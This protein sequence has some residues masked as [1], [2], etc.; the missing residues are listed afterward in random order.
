[1]KDMRYFADGQ[2]WVVDGIG[3]PTVYGVQP[4]RW[5]SYAYNAEDTDG[6]GVLDDRD[7]LRSHTHDGPLGYSGC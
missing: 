3:T 5:H 1:M 4:C 2:W 6:N 7:G